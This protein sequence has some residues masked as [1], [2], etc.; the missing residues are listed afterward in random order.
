MSNQQT[1]SPSAPAGTEILARAAYEAPKL[2]RLGDVRD[3]TLGGSAGTG[4]SG[5]AGSQQF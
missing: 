4:D 1:P 3:L 2:V 5:N